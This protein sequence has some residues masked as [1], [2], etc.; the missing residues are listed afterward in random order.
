MFDWRD[1]HFLLVLARTS[2][3][4][5]AARE[6]R[7]DHATV[8]RRIDALEAA[9][10]V[11]LIERLPRSSRLTA[12]GA[13]IVGQTSDM[14]AMAQAAQRVARGAGMSIS[15]VVRVSAPPVLTS[16]CIAPRIAEFRAAYPH[17]R[18][19][20]LAAR[21]TLA[22][23]RGE[24]D[25]ALRLSRLAKGEALTRK[26]G[27]IPFAAYATPR[28][29]ERDDKKWEFIAFDNSSGPPPQQAWLERCRAERAIAVEAS[30]L[31]SQQ[32]AARAGAGIALLPAIQGDADT[33]LRRVSLGLEPPQRDLWLVVYPDLRR[34]P[35]VRATMDFL[36]GVFR[37]L[38]SPASRVTQ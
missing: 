22:L 3:L 5:A 36:I 14:E 26:I 10:G 18:M 21:E 13:A 38:S 19:T 4:S 7:V 24:A 37:D 29:A 35:A 28:Y 9:L 20:L 11:K 6:L 23:D 12:T 34:S 15:G 2:S 31:F 33:A 1:L 16:F 30:D 17:L 25:L 32:A 8:G 27:S